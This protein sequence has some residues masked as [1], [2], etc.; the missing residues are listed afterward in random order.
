MGRTR[1][2]MGRTNTGR[3]TPHSE[4]AGQAAMQPKVSPQRSQTDTQAESSAKLLLLRKLGVVDKE[5]ESKSPS[6]KKSPA[7]ESG[8]V[9]NSPPPFVYDTPRSS[10]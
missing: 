10:S 8:R 5:R 4:G 6:P 2:A 9:Q 1:T 3:T 7:R